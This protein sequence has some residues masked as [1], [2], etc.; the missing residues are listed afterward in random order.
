MRWLILA[1]SLGC[2]LAT[3]WRGI[4]LFITN[5]GT[6]R[7]VSSSPSWWAITLCIGALFGFIGGVMAFNHRKLSLLF[8]LTATMLTFLGT[9]I[10]NL[11]QQN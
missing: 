2:T 9:R 1:L 6:A 7:V 5:L 8:L 4:M 11:L 3:L 10:L